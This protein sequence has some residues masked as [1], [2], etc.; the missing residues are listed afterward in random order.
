MLWSDPCCL[1]TRM[2]KVCSP[3]LLPVS[4]EAASKLPHPLPAQPCHPSLPPRASCSGQGTLACPAPSKAALSGDRRTLSLSRSDGARWVPAWA[5]DAQAQGEAGCAGSSV[6]APW[7]LGKAGSD[8]PSPPFH[9]LHPR[10][11][12]GTV[13]HP[14]SSCAPTSKRRSLQGSPT[15]DLQSSH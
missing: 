10:A 4:Q 8:V 12:T 5:G 15:P 2:G 1:F 13:P 11:S 6:P 14:P 7:H 3:C 9:P